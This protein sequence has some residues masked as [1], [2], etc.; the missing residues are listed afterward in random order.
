M[1]PKAAKAT[2]KTN[3]KEC[4]SIFYVKIL[5]GEE[6]LDLTVNAFCRPD[7]VA[8]FVKKQMI[9]LISARINAHSA[10]ESFQHGNDE[11][12][13]TQPD[14]LTKAKELLSM[15]SDVATQNLVLKGENDQTIFFDK[16]R[17][18]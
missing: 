14:Y 3:E 16:V 11:A 1:G 12:D 18:C 2:E 4:A 9:K 10:S 8:D 15:L 17:A 13:A 5:I 6:K 7:I